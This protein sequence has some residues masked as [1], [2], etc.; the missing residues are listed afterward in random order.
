MTLNQRQGHYEILWRY[1]FS[2]LPR[3][4]V[5]VQLVILLLKPMGVA[6]PALRVVIMVR[7]YS[8]AKSCVTASVLIEKC[9]ELMSPVLTSLL[10]S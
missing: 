1:I 5:F 2:S 9:F 4:T 7:R 10:F 3:L 8:T 6:A